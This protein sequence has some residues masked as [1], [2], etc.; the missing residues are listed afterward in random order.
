MSEIKLAEILTDSGRSTAD[1]AVDVISQRPELFDEA[2][3]LC[4]K[5]DGKM[6]LRAARVV[7]LVAEQ[8]PELFQPYFSD[9]VHRLDSLS[10]SS[11][12]RN[13][14]KVLTLYDLSDDEEL[15]S[16]IIDACFHR[17]ND[18]EEEVA[19]RAYATRVLQRFCRIYPE[20]TGEL[21]AALHILID[22]SKETL[23][24][25]SKNVLKE[26]YKDAV[27]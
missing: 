14:L 9:L 13:M 21:I 27:P 26:L 11:V 10:H 1:M 22:N 24:K 2:Y 3:Q 20:L 12:K 5:Q 17:M 15:H 16:L 19:T 23:S 18:F 4:M 25:Y 7:Q 6:A 8:M